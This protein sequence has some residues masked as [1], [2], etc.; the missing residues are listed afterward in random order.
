MEKFCKLLVEKEI[1]INFN[2]FKIL[3]LDKYLDKNDILK[4]I[5]CDSKYIDEIFIYFVEKEIDIPLYCLNNIR[6]VDTKIEDFYKLIQSCFNT[7]SNNKL[8]QYLDEFIDKSYKKNKYKIT[9]Y[10]QKIILHELTSYNNFYW[11]QEKVENYYNVNFEDL[12]MVFYENNYDRVSYKTYYDFFYPLAN[13]YEILKE[14]KHY[15]NFN[16]VYGLTSNKRIFYY[17][18]E[19]KFPYE[20]KR[21]YSVNHLV[22][23]LNYNIF[24]SSKYIII[25][26]KTFTHI[27]DDINV[28]IFLLNYFENNVLTWKNLKLFLEENYD[29]LNFCEY[30]Y[31]YIS[32]RINDGH[33]QYSQIDIIED[34]YNYTINNYVINKSSLLGYFVFEHHKKSNNM[35]DIVFNKILKMHDDL[36]PVINKLYNTDINNIK[37]YYEHFNFENYDPNIT[38]ILSAFDLRVYGLDLRAELVRLFTKYCKPI[39]IELNTLLINIYSF[40]N[41]DIENYKYIYHKNPIPHIFLKTEMC[42]Y[43]DNINKLTQNNCT[44]LIKLLIDENQ[45]FY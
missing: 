23:A 44:Y 28:P 45:H 15:N 6:Y 18:Y 10:N 16:Y 3:K 19:Y 38:L 21:S 40:Q 33:F 24:E 26:T 7:F 32:Y 37:I 25:D 41:E 13:K 11:N 1:N 30:N 29:Y 22:T 31:D 5:K 27:N 35:L 9:N 36:I 42:Y 20:N 39:D 8:T 12:I 4:I 2:E 34:K 14:N 43:I 17:I